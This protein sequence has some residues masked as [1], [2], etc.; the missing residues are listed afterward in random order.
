MKVLV[1]GAAGFIG[2]HLALALLERGDEVV[3][4][5]NLN[6]Y[7]DPQL[8]QD[9]LDVI[10]A[11]ARADAFTFL[12]Q[13]IADRHAMSALFKEF[14]A[15]TRSSRN[16]NVCLFVCSF[17]CSVQTCLEL[18][19]SQRFLSILLEVSQRSLSGLSAVS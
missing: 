3:G 8:K 10:C 15:P 18:L 13:D 9:R 19:N 2:F 4:V 16:A 5:D 14:L 12:K 6:D 11:H 17:V 1:T 7:Y